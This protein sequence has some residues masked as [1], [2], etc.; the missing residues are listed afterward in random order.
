MAPQKIIYY[1]LCK[2]SFYYLAVKNLFSM[3]NLFWLF[4]LFFV[5]GCE[6]QKARKPVEKASHVEQKLTPEQE[7]MK[8]KIEQYAVFELT[9][10]LSKLSENQKKMIPLLMEAAKLT[11][12]VFW[13]Q[14]YGVKDSL[15]KLVND[16]L[17]WEYVEINYGPWDRMDENKPFVKGVGPK[18]AGANFY[19]KDM[20]KEEFE[21]AELPDKT[22]LYTLLRR[23]EAGKLITIPYHV[24]Y[25][26][27]HEKMAGLLRK[28]AELAEDEGFKKYLLARADALLTDEYRTSDMLWM[29]MKDNTLDLVIGPIE[30]YEDQLFG[31]KAA[32]EAYVLVKDKEW[33]EKL[34]KYAAL[35]PEMQRGLPV[36]DKYKKEKPGRDS[37]L[38]AYDA[39]FYAGEANTGGKTIAINLP[40]DEAV[41]LKKGSRRLQLKNVMRAKFEKILVPI[42]DILI[43]PEQRKHIT[44]DAFF[45][46]TMFHEVAH[47]LGIKNTVTGKGTVREALKD[48][49]SALEEGKAD[50]LGLY[51]V[52]RLHEKNMLENDIRDNM[53]TFLAGIFRSIRFGA[54][55]AHGMANLIRFNY[56]KDKG[57]FTRNEHGQY[58]VDFVKMKQAMEDLSRDILTLQGNGD[59]EAV[60]NFVEKYGRMDSTLKSD[61]EKVNQ[62]NIPVDIRF[63]QGPEILGLK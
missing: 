58:A 54:H 31:Y 47:G 50:V 36:E 45:G 5:A 14:S 48:L 44:F 46:N 37:D 49:A 29:D 2:A 39:I 3:R 6:N 15:R 7:E 16:S 33:S 21:K 42:A 4:I 17:T 25:Q 9:T 53:V 12:E 26:K 1:K 8:K 18:P 28:A 41:Q 52:D 59:Y 27:Q 30:T 38:G 57:A 10:D 22:S 60:K 43:V 24:A 51:L 20:T 63:K 61:L 34:K 19:P 23:D 11:D 32:H 62:A 56:F 55:E 40:N 13:L 35:L